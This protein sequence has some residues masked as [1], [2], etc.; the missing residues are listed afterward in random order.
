MNTSQRLHGRKWA[1]NINNPCQ[2]RWPH[3]LWILPHLWAASGATLWV[4]IT[5]WADRHFSLSNISHCETP[6]FP[7]YTHLSI[8]IAVCNYVDWFFL[9]NNCRRTRSC[10]LLK[11]WNKHHMGHLPHKIFWYRLCLRSAVCTYVRVTV[12]FFAWVSKPYTIYIQ[13]VLLNATHNYCNRTCWECTFDLITLFTSNWC[14]LD[15]FYGVIDTA[16]TSYL[17]RDHTCNIQG[18]ARTT[19]M[20]ETPQG[21]NGLALK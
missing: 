3:K 12:S 11:F 9:C 1:Q 14:I 21:I 20:M 6:L 15:E 13:L 4:R 5:I 17:Y 2:T 16:S 18:T 7:T 19:Y 10:L 8:C